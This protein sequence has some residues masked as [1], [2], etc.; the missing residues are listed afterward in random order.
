MH[1]STVPWISR[2]RLS[3]HSVST[4][5]QCWARDISLSTLSEWIH[6]YT[7][8][9][10]SKQGLRHS[11]SSQDPDQNCHGL[12]WALVERKTK[13]WAFSRYLRLETGFSCYSEGLA[14]SSYWCVF[15]NKWGHLTSWD[16]GEEYMKDSEKKKKNCKYIPPNLGN[17]SQNNWRAHLREVAGA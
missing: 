3:G 6:L 4:E 13:P 11:H 16:T 8:L 17:I 7:Y 5:S 10:S 1:F 15:L 14:C 9:L 12:F 2:Q